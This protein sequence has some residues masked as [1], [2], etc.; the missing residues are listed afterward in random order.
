[1]PSFY[2]LAKY[3]R[4]KAIR[5]IDAEVNSLRSGAKKVD[6]RKS[7]VQGELENLNRALNSA[8]SS[9]IPLYLLDEYLTK[10]PVY[11]DNSDRLESESIRLLSEIKRVESKLTAASSQIDMLG[12]LERQRTYL[13]KFALDQYQDEVAQDEFRAGSN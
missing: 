3:Q 7:Q 4:Y 5:K 13:E 9:G 2:K 10:V 12:D 1:M 6:V 11:E 8:V